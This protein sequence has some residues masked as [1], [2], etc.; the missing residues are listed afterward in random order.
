M[1][2]TSFCLLCPGAVALR[3]RGTT[4]GV[5][6]PFVVAQVECTGQEEQLF[7]CNTTEYSNSVDGPQCLTFSDEAGVVCQGMID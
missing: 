1:A 2:S 6:P 4:G 3:S 7:E 5:V